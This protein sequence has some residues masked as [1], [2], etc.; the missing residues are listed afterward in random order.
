MKRILFAAA[1]LA[2]ASSVALAQGPGAG[3][4][5]KGPGFKFGPNNTRGWSLMTPQERTEHQRKMMNFKSY[6]ECKAYQQE[7][8]KQMEARAKEQGKPMPSAPRGNMCDR[9]KQAGRFG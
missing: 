6:D 7:H 1:A 5:G 4:A 8:H 2:L 9:M 3:P